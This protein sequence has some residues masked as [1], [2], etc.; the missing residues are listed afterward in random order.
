MGWRH[1]N[2][3]LSLSTGLQSAHRVLMVCSVAIR[4]RR[5]VFN[6]GLSISR[7]TESYRL[8]VINRRQ[9]SVN[10]TLRRL[11]SSLGVVNKGDTHGT[12][13][14]RGSSRRKMVP[15]NLSLTGRRM[16]LVCI[17]LGDGER[18]M[19]KYSNFRDWDKIPEEVHLFSKIAYTVFFSKNAAYSK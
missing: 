9:S 4:G 1:G 11:S 6:F 13:P 14:S 7:S 10:V 5:F 15:W 8:S 12:S 18:A 3:L 19:V 17:A 2:R 16:L